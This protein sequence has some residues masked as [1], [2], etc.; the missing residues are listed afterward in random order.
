M[1]VSVASTEES[2]AAA[3]VKRHFSTGDMLATTSGSG[4]TPHLVTCTRRPKS[5]GNFYVEAFR[6]KRASSFGVSGYQGASSFGVS[7]HQGASSYGGESPPGGIQ[8][9]G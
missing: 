3:P 6:S 7:G 8:L 9:R 1:C 5:E 2:E 4:S